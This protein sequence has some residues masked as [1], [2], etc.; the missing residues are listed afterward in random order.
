MPPGSQALDSPARMS[1][2]KRIAIMI[3]N[4]IAAVAAVVFWFWVPSTGTNALVFGVSIVVLLICVAVLGNLDDNFI[5]KHIK[6]GYWP[7]K[8]IDWNPHPDNHTAGKKHGE[9]SVD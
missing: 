6:E 2:V 5:S 1:A 3:I 8:P 9:G 7:S 4:G